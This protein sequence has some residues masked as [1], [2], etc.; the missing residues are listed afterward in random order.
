MQNSSF[1]KVLVRCYSIAFF[2]EPYKM[3]L[4]N[5][6][7]IGNRFQINIFAIVFVNK[8][9]CPDQLSNDVRLGKVLVPYFQYLSVIIGH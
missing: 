3:K 4:G 6:G 1:S 8:P 2:K 5:E 7:K 9:F